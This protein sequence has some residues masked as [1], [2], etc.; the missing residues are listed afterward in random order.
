M[1]MLKPTPHPGGLR[2]AVQ[3]LDCESQRRDLDYIPQT[4]PLCGSRRFIHDINFWADAPITADFGVLQLTPDGRW[5]PARRLKRPHE[6]TLMERICFWRKWPHVS[7]ET[8]NAE[9]RVNNTTV[10]NNGG[11]ADA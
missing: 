8:A 7:Q 10:I 5:I 3:C 2:V 11:R 1:R 4:C 9:Y 6:F